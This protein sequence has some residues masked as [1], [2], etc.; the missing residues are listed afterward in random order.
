MNVYKLITFEG[1]PYNSWVHADRLK[2]MKS[3]EVTGTWY[4][5]LKARHYAQLDSHTCT[6]AQANTMI[7][8]NQAFGGGLLL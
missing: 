1:E 2:A 5:P 4:N 8:D 7:E 6:N 3:S